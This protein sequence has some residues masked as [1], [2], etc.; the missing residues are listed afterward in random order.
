MGVEPFRGFLYSYD[1]QLHATSLMEK[2]TNDIDKGLL[3]ELNMTTA[4]RGRLGELAD[5]ANNREREREREINGA[6]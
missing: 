3:E 2:Y 5:V 6:L 1:L 4:I